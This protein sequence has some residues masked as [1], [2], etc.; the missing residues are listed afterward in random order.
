MDDEGTVNVNITTEND[1]NKVQGKTK[2]KPEYVTDTSKFKETLLQKNLTDFFDVTLEPFSYKIFEESTPDHVLYKSNPNKLFMSDYFVLDEGIF[3]LNAKTG[4]PL[5]GMGE[6]AGSIFYKNEQG[7][8]HSRY[9]FDQ[10]NPID[11]GLP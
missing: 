1:Y 10:A 3:S 5:L 7:G 6:R 8:I 4:Y 9:A 11:D 2:F